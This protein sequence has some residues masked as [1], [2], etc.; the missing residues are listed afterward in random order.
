M[1]VLVP[2]SVGEV[3]DKIT[4]LEI[5]ES[6]T[7]DPEKLANIRKEKAALKAHMPFPHGV[8]DEMVW[9]LKKAN[10]EIWRAEDALHKLEESKTFDGEF[11]TY[12]RSAYINNGKRSKIKRQINMLTNSEIV[13]EKIF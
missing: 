13:E 3:F 10:L 7:T 11:I 1:I 4:I 12:A 5:K 8:P 9:D 6:F 2:V